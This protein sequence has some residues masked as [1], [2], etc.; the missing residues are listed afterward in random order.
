M[1]WEE[2][3]KLSPMQMTPSQADDWLTRINLTIAQGGL[4][5]EPEQRKRYDA[6]YQGL[7]KR[8][9]LMNLM[10]VDA[11]E[12]E[13]EPEPPTPLRAEELARSEAIRKTM[14]FLPEM[15]RKRRDS[16]YRKPLSD[17]VEEIVGDKE[18]KVALPPSA[19]V[20]R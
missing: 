11:L 13:P 10:F 18:S 2:I 4:I 1:T 3:E 9:E 14:R 12:K 5:L 6:V 15:R 19:V 17:L 7:Q 20:E 8:T 16:K